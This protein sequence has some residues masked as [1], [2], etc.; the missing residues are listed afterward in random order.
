MPVLFGPIVIRT[1]EA[2]IVICVMILWVAAIALFF[3]RWGK[4]RM[5]EPYQPKFHEEEHRPSCPMVELAGA[6]GIGHSITGGGK[7]CVPESFEDF[8]YQ[9]FFLPELF[10]CQPK[11]YIVD[12]ITNPFGMRYSD[13]KIRYQ[14]YS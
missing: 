10:K 11:M 9:T 7:P 14:P 12:Q 3:N 5:L 8:K 2:F 1:E 13:G 4:I 6:S